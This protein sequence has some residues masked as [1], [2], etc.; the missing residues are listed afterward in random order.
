MLDGLLQWII[1]FSGVLLSTAR[2]I[3]PILVILLGFQIAILRKPIPNLRRVIIGFIY[4][5]VGLALFLQGLEQALFPIGRLMAEQLTNPMF[6][7]GVE[8]FTGDVQWQD[9]FWV[10]IFAISIGFSTTI[11]EPSLMAV[12]LK[13]NVKSAHAAKQGLNTAFPISFRGGA[14]MGL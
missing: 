5:L 1:H 2:D 11:A 8:S 10:Y 12:A 9:Y 7:H 4:V 6:I 3:L 14:V 13:A